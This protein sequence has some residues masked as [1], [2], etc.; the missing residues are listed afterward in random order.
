MFFF[1][2]KSHPLRFIHGLGRI[3][4]HYPLIEIHY[5]FLLLLLRGRFSSTQESVQIDSCCCSC[6]LVLEKQGGK[7]E[8]KLMKAIFLGKKTLF[9][10][11]LDAAVN[12]VFLTGF[13]SS[14]S[15][16]SPSSSAAGADEPF[17]FFP[18]PCKKRERG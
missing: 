10:L 9:A 15:C 8:L 13:S 16:C 3:E 17:F 2:K 4:I 14:S 12:E 7:N 5:P 6:R 11:R 1:N 18:S